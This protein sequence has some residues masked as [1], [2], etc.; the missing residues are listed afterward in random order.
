M[1][2]NV[3]G[4]SLT[5]RKRGDKTAA[6]LLEYQENAYLKKLRG[7]GLMAVNWHPTRQS[8]TEVLL[9]QVGKR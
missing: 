6:Q 7:L 3:S 5:V 2:V 1:I 4:Y 9:A 8:I